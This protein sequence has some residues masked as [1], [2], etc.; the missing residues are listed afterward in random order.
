MPSNTKLIKQMGVAIQRKRQRKLVNFFIDTEATVDNR[1]YD[2]Y[3]PKGSDEEE[4][5][6]QKTPPKTKCFTKKNFTLATGTRGLDKEDT[7]TPNA[8]RKTS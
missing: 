5:C 6:L 8:S 7:F 4:E 3:P 2:H 1:F